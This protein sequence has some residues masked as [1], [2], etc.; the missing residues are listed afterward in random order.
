MEYIK[1][2]VMKDKKVSFTEAKAALVSL[3]LPFVHSERASEGV[4]VS[5]SRSKKR[6]EDQK[7]EQ[8][9]KRE[10]SKER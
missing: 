10:I 6:K 3:S 9:E 7:N 5:L 1:R 8:Q 4:S 2:S